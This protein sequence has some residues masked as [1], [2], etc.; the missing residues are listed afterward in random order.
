MK[1][2]IFNEKF[3]A[4]P[5]SGLEYGLW[6][7]V[8]DVKQGMMCSGNPKCRPFKTAKDAEDAIQERY[9]EVSWMYVVLESKIIADLL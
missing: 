1:C 8:D 6:Y 3:K 9:G 4:Y 7:N 2:Y 5:Y